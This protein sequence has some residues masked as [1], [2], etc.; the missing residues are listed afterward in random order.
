[1]TFD[2]TSSAPTVAS[3]T[4]ARSIVSVTPLSGGRARIT[5]TATD[6]GGSQM[7]AMQTFT[8]TVANRAPVAVGTLAALSLKKGKIERKIQYLRHACFAARPFCDLD[9]INTQF[10]RWRDE[11]AHRRPHPDQPNRS[12]AE[13][14]AEEKP[15]LLPLPA[16][17]FETDL[18]RAVRCGKTPYYVR[19]DRNLYSIPHTHVCKPLTWSPRPPASASSTDRPS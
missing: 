16:N 7:S 13:V 1:M 14:W 4:V 2:A 15:R 19:F 6:L 8:V 3:V 9:D 18:V 12:V 10:R 17:P 5:V 11:V